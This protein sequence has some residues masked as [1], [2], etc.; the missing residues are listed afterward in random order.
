MIVL[1]TNVISELM[2]RRPNPKVVSWCDSQRHSQLVTT[3]ITV[4]ELHAGVERLKPG[5]RKSELMDF[6]IWTLD[7][8]L[9]GRVLNF[10]RRAA[11]ETARFFARCKAAGRSVETRD[12]QIAGIAI[13]RRV[14][15]ATRNV[16]HFEDAGIKI[17]DPWS[18]A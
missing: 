5:R 14:P 3:A 17:I 13:A 18:G 12:S 2:N 1:D 11:V 9:E 16:T 8:L 6:L 15:V 7:D 4:M 10:D